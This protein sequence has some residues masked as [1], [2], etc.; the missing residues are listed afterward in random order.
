MGVGVGEVDEEGDKDF[1]KEAI[2]F[3]SLLSILVF[4]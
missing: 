2:I 1:D 3:W 4:F